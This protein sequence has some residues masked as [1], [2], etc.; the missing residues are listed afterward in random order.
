MHQ[1]AI[2]GVYA[3]KAIKESGNYDEIVAHPDNTL[4]GFVW[5]NGTPFKVFKTGKD[6]FFDPLPVLRVHDAAG[7]APARPGQLRQLELLHY[8]GPMPQTERGA[9]RLL[10]F[11][12]VYYTREVK[13]KLPP[14][15][16]QL[17]ALR[18][19]GY[20]GPLPKTRDEARRLLAQLQLAR[21]KA[22]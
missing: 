17:Q 14:A 8:D 15:E 2:R 20:Q 5:I 1:Q 3:L 12:Q 7:N 18:N 16:G 6:A 19:F 11:W 22:A 13:Q 9:E 21:R 4:E 10:D